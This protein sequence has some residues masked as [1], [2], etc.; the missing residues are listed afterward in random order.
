M[1]FA[2]FV[3][4]LRSMRKGDSG[5]SGTRSAKP[6]STPQA[7]IILMRVPMFR[8]EMVPASILFTEAMETPQRSANSCWETQQLRLRAFFF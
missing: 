6:S 4:V 5:T 7:R 3:P 2:R 1:H 8:S